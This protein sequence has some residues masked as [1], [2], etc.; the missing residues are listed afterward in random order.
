MENRDMGSSDTPVVERTTTDRTP[1]RV[2]LVLRIGVTGHRS[3]PTDAHR[4][5]RAPDVAAIRETVRTVLG[6]IRDAFEQVADTHGHLFAVTPEKGTLRV[7][8]ALAAGADQWIAQEALGIGCE[9]HALL[10]FHRDEFRHDFAPGPELQGFDALLAQASAVLELDGKVDYDNQ[11]QRTP[12]YRSYQAVGRAVLNQTDLLIA[13]WDG[14]PSQGRGGTGQIV[15][16]AVQRGIP[17]VWIQWNAPHGWRLHLPGWHQVEHQAATADDPR[18]L[19]DI[20]R[21]LL[22]PPG[23]DPGE[24]QLLQDY[25]RESQKRGNLQ[26]G[27]WT[28]FSNLISGDLFSRQ[29]WRHARAAFRVDNFAAQA[30]DW[31]EKQSTP[32]A[33]RAHP[34]EASM[35]HWVD[36]RFR[37]HFAWAN[38][39]SRYYGNLYRGAF[40]MNY[41]LGA[42]AVLLALVCIAQGIEG[43]AQAPWIVAELLVILG[44]LALTHTGR[45]R[46]WHQRWIDYRTLTERLRVARS[47]SLFGGGGPRV[48]YASHLAGYGNP[49]HSWMHWH[50]RAIERAAGVPPV[51]F[52]SAYLRACQE[53]WRDRLVQDQLNYHRPT[54]DQF[55]KLDH[56]L[57]LAGDGLFA[58][59]LLA[60]LLH[61]AHLGVGEAPGWAWLPHHLPGWLTLACAVLP[62]LGAAFAAIRSQ[63][64]AQRLAQ[65]SRAMEEAF[66]Q[67]QVDLATVSTAE[68]A[69]NSQ[70]LRECA[71]R[72]SELM[73]KETLDWRVVFQDQPLVL[74]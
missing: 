47:L 26:H 72:V 58:A 5:R 7:V 4:K 36:A 17:V 51:H 50:Y 31:G 10:P 40:V 21:E 66:T 65:R 57:H 70:L 2:P 69:L 37:Q 45:L 19:A 25:F 8:S 63:S 28:L 38:G 61:L 22:L 46:R 1:P 62:A 6:V 24:A 33:Q 12:D 56:R 64:E 35:R 34:V 16:E 29:G 11:G 67:L 73:I 59:T 44:I 13:V 49:A 30:D 27:V 55:A 53:F 74:P 9:L 39:L 18:R 32:G 60:C 42:V 41:L 43:T 15:D 68:T 14:L 23:D 48:V 3:E 52:T 71:D 20:V 54:A